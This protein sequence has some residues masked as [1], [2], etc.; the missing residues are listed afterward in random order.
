MINGVVGIG[1]VVEGARL[2]MDMA[3]GAV[4]RGAVGVIP[5]TVR[6]QKW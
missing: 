6:D 5:A 3:P 2:V 4:V 1:T